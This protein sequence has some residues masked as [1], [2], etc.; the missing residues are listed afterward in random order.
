M[1]LISVVV[2]C[3][4]EKEVIKETHERLSSELEKSAKYK[5]FKYEIIYI[6]DG[7]KDN[8]LQILQQIEKEFNSKINLN[9]KV[10][11]IALAKNFGHQTALSAGLQFSKGDAVI[12]IDADLQDPPEAINKMLEKWQEGFDV[13]HAVRTAR[14]GETWFKLSSAKVFYILVRKLTKVD[15]PLNAGDFRL[16]S[17]RTV[18]LFNAM[19]ERNR[20]IRGMVPW[21][22]LKQGAI[23]YERSARF[24]GSTKYPLGKMLKLAF[25]GITSF[26]N[27]P[28]QSAYY[29]GFFVA[30]ISI[31]YAIYIV[32]YSLIHGFPVQGWSSI[33]V[34]ILFIGSV[35]L[36]TIGILGEYVGRIY[37]EVKKRPLFIIDEEESR[38]N[39]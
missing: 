2:P 22:G 20:F 26:S 18:K 6:N 37:D 3:Y 27:T 34:I 25:D 10:V 5:K 15:I 28:L 14:A 24:A 35:Q 39:K 16:M 38:L 13:V 17:K 12:S 33:M 9:G 11:I 36:I 32:I 29:L 30:I 21:I 31:L 7:S 1:A 4:N 23:Y 19:P 8:T